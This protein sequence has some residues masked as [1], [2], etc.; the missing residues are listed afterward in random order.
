MDVYV[1]FY[2][3]WII[4]TAIG[5]VLSIL[6]MPQNSLIASLSYG[7]IGGWVFAFFFAAM[8]FI[9][10]SVKNKKQESSTE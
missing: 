7:A 8:Y 4:A 5:T 10:K 6:T 3:L 9:S 1:F 2:I